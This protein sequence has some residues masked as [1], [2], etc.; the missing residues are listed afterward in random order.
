MN[1]RIPQIPLWLPLSKD[2][3]VKPIK[4]SLCTCGYISMSHVICA[5]RISIAYMSQNGVSYTTHESRCVAPY[6]VVHHTHVTSCIYLD[7][8]DVVTKGQGIRGCHAQ[9]L[10]SPGKCIALEAETTKPPPSPTPPC[11]SGECRMSS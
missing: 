2:D 8:H 11:K 1:P 9:G 3:V 10:C 7:V 4:M 6:Q 5:V